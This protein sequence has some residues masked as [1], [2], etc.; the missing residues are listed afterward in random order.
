M[1]LI[2]APTL[3]AELGSTDA[4]Q[5]NAGPCLMS[6]H[7]DSINVAHLKRHVLS[8]VGLLTVRRCASQGLGRAVVATRCAGMHRPLPE[9]SGPHTFRL[10]A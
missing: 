10:L 1:A 9:F 7:V 6:F 5:Y 4:C 2:F 3:C 8:N